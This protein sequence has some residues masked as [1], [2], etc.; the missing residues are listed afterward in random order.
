MEIL[1][2][3]RSHLKNSLLVLFAHISVH[4][5]AEFSEKKLLP[6][7]Q[8]HYGSDRGQVRVTFIE[9]I[10][11]YSQSL[12]IDLRYASILLFS[13]PSVQKMLI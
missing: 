2:I 13:L 12:F 7:F 8:I 3:I 10:N 1:I 11:H 9:G 5:I 6:P 4:F